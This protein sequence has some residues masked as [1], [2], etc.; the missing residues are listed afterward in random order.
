MQL[1]DIVSV[2]EASKHWYEYPSEMPK[3]SKEVSSLEGCLEMPLNYLL[4]LLLI[5]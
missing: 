4:K 1:D 3:L 2:Y 5:F